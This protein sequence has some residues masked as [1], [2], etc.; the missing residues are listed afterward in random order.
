MSKNITRRK[1]AVIT[2][3]KLRKIIKEEL[4]REIL[5]RE[6]IFDSLKN[7]F[8]RLK[9]D[10][11]RW[12][13]EKAAELSKNIS[14]VLGS[15]V[16][17]GDVTSF[18]DSLAQQ[19]GGAS[20]EELMGYLPF[21]AELQDLE[22]EKSLDI[23][24]LISTTS[25]GSSYDSLRFDSLMTEERFLTRKKQSLNEGVLTVSIGAWYTLSKTVVTTCSLTAF[26]LEQA[27]S[28]AKFLGFK[29]L[30]HVL[31]SIAKKIEHAEEWFLKK[32][33]FPAPVQYA[34]YL[35]FTG[36]KKIRGDAQ[37]FLSF[38][39]FQADKE[40]KENVIK[41]LKIALLLTIVVEALSHIGHALMDF[42]ENVKKSAMQIVHGIEHV[43]LETRSAAKTGAELAKAGKDVLAARAAAS[44]TP[45]A[46]R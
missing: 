29:K 5:I 40:L 43:G 8:S 11:K 44:V 36:A 39:E 26:A 2:E 16:L 14:G 38:K 13:L 30:E 37:K 17:P 33:A 7:A 34:A 18:L 6:G 25:E 27:A 4:A 24:S 22:K 35:A 3:A 21:V 46:V 9:D 15:L 45:A 20:V 28:M 23:A 19:E 32:V 41:G 10:A 42:F 1:S 12:V 31:E